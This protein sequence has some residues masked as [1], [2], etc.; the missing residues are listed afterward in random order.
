MADDR[1]SG[2]SAGAGTHQR[3]E[4]AP[5]GGPGRD[6]GSLLGSGRVAVEAAPGAAPWLSA[7][8]DR[9]LHRVMGAQGGR[10]G[11]ERE[12]AEERAGRG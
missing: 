12:G 10:D 6:E 8:M 5:T 4:A 1:T 9:G 11:A 2:P 3:N 7:M